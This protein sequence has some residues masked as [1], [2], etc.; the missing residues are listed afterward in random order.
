MES[1]SEI[2]E[3]QKEL[4]VLMDEF[5]RICRENHIDYSLHA[6]TMLGAVR[7]G[8]FI[9][10][11]D[12]ADVVFMRSEFVK[13]RD[14]VLTMQKKQKLLFEPDFS[15][16]P[17]LFMQRPGKPKVWL[18]IYLYD[19]IS[20]HKLVQ[21]LKFAL[22]AWNMAWMRSKE[23]LALTKAHGMY[24]GWKYGVI[25]AIHCLGVPFSE[26]TKNRVADKTARRFPG[27]RTYIH[28]ANDQYVA[29]KLVLP[30]GVMAE[31]IEIPF[32]SSRY[33]IAKRYHEVLVSSYGEDYMT[34]KKQQGDIVSHNLFR[35]QQ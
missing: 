10:W 12:D 25:Y 6:G 2:K 27:K 35:S 14:A 13:F 34:P 1:N 5:H 33:M 17:R 21:K 11:D 20:E 22:L 31:Y 23:G 26:G 8:G 18:D 19:Y 29:L 15:F 9:P 3:I 4:L 28:R 24:R 32:E 16:G 30:V 7:E